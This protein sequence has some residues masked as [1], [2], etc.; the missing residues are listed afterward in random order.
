MLDAFKRS[1]LNSN[2][3]V[4]ISAGIPFGRNHPPG[5]TWGSLTFLSKTPPPG[6]NFLT[7]SPP[8]GQKIEGK[9]VVF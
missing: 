9:F 3:K 7:K 2:V 4:C 1:I 8:R 5:L 6:Q